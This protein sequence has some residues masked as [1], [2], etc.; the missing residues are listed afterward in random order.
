MLGGW[1]FCRGNSSREVRVSCA[2][3]RERLGHGKRN[4]YGA[5]YCDICVCYATFV[6]LR[7]LWKTQFFL[8]NL[9]KIWHSY[10]NDFFDLWIFEFHLLG[11]AFFDEWIEQRWTGLLHSS[12]IPVYGRS[13]QLLCLTDNIYFFNSSNKQKQYINRW[14]VFLGSEF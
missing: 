3:F 10:R 7:F 12:H 9:N 2:A 13:R 14:L 1:G 5:F 11:W 6:W 8:W 4:L